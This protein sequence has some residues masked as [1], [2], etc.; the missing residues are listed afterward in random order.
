MDSER[1]A[2]VKQY[3][4]KVC[5]N[6]R[7]VVGRRGSEVACATYKQEI[8]CSIPGRAEYAPTLCS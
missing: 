6:N 3:Q 1:L 2:A 4:V 8:A 7:R 5:L